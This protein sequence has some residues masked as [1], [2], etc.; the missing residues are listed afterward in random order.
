MPDSDLQEAKERFESVRLQ[1]ESLLQML[2]KE[3]VTIARNE[4]G[5]LTLTHKGDEPIATAPHGFLSPSDFSAAQAL[6][7]KMHP[8]E[9]PAANGVVNGALNFR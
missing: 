4:K 3:G 8:L 7:D 5:A 2:Q 9:P 6:L 1:Q